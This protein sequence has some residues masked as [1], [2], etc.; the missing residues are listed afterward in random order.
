MSKKI[1]FFLPPIILAVITWIWLFYDKSRWY[2]YRTEWQFI[3]LLILHL[4]VPLFYLVTGFITVLRRI[5][6]N[7]RSNADVFYIVGSIA[8]FFVSL[9]GAFIFLIFT[10]GA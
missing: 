6:V 2:T 5:N 1:K 4:L 7:T 10:S 9:F 8:M 3:P